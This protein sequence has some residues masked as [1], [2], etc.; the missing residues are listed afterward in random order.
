MFIMLNI[1]ELYLIYNINSETVFKPSRHLFCQNRAKHDSC[2][3]LSA[4][5][6]FSDAENEPRDIH[7]LQGLPLYGED[8]I[9][10]GQRPPSIKVLVSLAEPLPLRAS[11]RLF[12][13]IPHEEVFIGCTIIGQPASEPRTFS[14]LSFVS[15]LLVMKEKNKSAGLA[16]L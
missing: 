7:P 8:A 9:D 16:L 12:E 11:D 6:S 2:D 13:N 14:H 15:F 3:N 1:L 5:R 4:E 10:F